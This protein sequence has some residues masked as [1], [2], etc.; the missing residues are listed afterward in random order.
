M[1][2]APL[3]SNDNAVIDVIIPTRNRPN[4]TLEA[5]DSVRRQTYPHWR[6]FVVDDASE[7]DTAERATE[8]AREDRRIVVLRRLQRG[9][10]DAARQTGFEQASAPLVAILDSDDLWYADKLK[11]QLTYWNRMRCRG[12]ELEVLFCRFKY[13]DL[14]GRRVV[15]PWPPQP[16][17][18][19]WTPFI[20]YNTSTP[21]MSRAALEH[22][23]GFSSPRLRTA[24]QM[25]LFLRLTRNHRVA[26]VPKVL[27]RCRHHGGERNSDGLGSTAA[28]EEAASLFRVHSDALAGDRRRRAWLRGWVGG[29]Y[30][31]A[32]CFEVGVRQLRSA[33]RDAGVFSGSRM[34]A[35]YGPLAVRGLL[36]SRRPQRRG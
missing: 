18:R 3:R 16:W 17:S 7:D 20:I 32:G 34:C 2:D 36:G 4:L 5:V 14:D 28:A 35:H 33:L 19:R 10:S 6:L 21:L 11:H 30:L 24:D 23:G 26:V 15:G 27:V 29:R 8:I 9:G 13:S 25:D 31:Q 22:V 1:H 12:R